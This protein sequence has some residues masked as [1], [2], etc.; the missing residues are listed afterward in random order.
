MSDQG[1]G[2]KCL[3]YNDEYRIE[4]FFEGRPISIWE[5]RS[6]V[7]LNQ[8]LNCLVDFNFNKDCVAKIAAHR[9]LDNQNLAIDVAIK[10]WG[11]A[12]KAR[13]PSMRGKLL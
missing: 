10:E 6:P 11:P 8:I 4:S 3:F 2:P 9:P 12:V 7:I 13:L 5:M 1:L